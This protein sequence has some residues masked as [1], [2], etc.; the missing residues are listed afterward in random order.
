M[1]LSFADNYQCCWY[2][3]ILQFDYVLRLAFGFDHS[4]EIQMHTRCDLHLRCGICTKA[5]GVM[6]MMQQGLC[7]GVEEEE[8]NAKQVIRQ[9]NKDGRFHSCFESRGNLACSLSDN[10]HTRTAVKRDVPAL[11]IVRL[12]QHQCLIY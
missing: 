5:R 3:A 12:G 9:M 10:I 11:A 6:V 8:R 2:M 7:T 1:A 4:L